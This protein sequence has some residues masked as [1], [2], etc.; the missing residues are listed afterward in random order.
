MAALDG[1]R[2][3]AQLTASGLYLVALVRCRSAFNGPAAAAQGRRCLSS[4]GQQRAG[5]SSERL[6]GAPAAAGLE[7]KVCIVTGGNAGVGKATA[8]ELAARGA[9][10]IIACRSAKKGEEAVQDISLDLRVRRAGKASGVQALPL[11]LSSFQ[12]IRS[13]VKEFDGLGLPLDVLVNN[14][15]IMA[16]PERAITV[17]GFESQW[18]VNYLGHFLLTQELL[19]V[20]NAAR[21]I[22]DA[23]LRIVNLTSMTHYGGHIHF[24]DLNFLR[25][26]HAFAAY[27]Q[28]KLAIV[29]STKELQRRQPDIVAVS[30]HPGLINTALARGFFM[31]RVPGPLRGLI[32]PLYDLFLKDPEE[33]VSTLM[34]A[35]TAPAGEV[36]GGFVMDGMVRQSHKKSYDVELAS[37]LWATSMDLK[38]PRRESW[39]DAAAADL[40]LPAG[41][42]LLAQHF[43]LGDELGRGKFGIVREATSHLNG[44]RY[45]CKTLDKGELA[46]PRDRQAVLR[47]VA[48]LRRAGGAAPGGV[49]ALQGV[50]ED[51]DG[52]H[53]VMELCASGDLFSHIEARGRLH[54]PEAAAVLADVAATVAALHAR[55][56]VHRDL[57]PENILLAERPRARGRY[58]AKIADF[59]LAVV[60]NGAERL[61]E[62]VGSPYYVA[63]EVILGTHGV[64]ADVWSL[65]VILYIL[66]SGVPPFWGDSDTRIYD[67]IC[68]QEPDLE[69]EPWPSVS[70]DAKSLIK[71]MLR[72]DPAVRITAKEVY[73]S[74][75][76]RQQSLHLSCSASL[77]STFQLPR[78]A[79]SSGPD[80]EEAK[81]VQAASSMV[82]SAYETA[83]ADS[84][85]EPTILSRFR[86]RLQAA[87][88]A[89]QKKLLEEVGGADRIH[90]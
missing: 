69:S 52:V 75:W 90:C 55:G 9:Q 18:Q 3:E 78:M 57:K 41:T 37:K 35:I 7:G 74:T 21:R 87:T 68:S 32:A 71:E 42:R 40:V 28:S 8:R 53:L 14:A 88:A 86:Q 84:T 4:S 2:R 45:A 47:E 11:D 54:E 51:P 81:A 49:V 70:A 63:P 89:L 64:E 33:A 1:A 25:R 67:A 29:L 6:L 5:S 36:A 27:A 17:D 77:R 79:S 46:T 73:H 24:D 19:R 48:I 61:A 10:V 59:G 12:S 26:Y 16:P 85:C 22:S 72:S 34:Y 56:I 82:G 23:P 43:S 65:G 31:S 44:R 20:P 13:F 80:V 39:S 30:V 38:R 62:F 60:L 83:G 58:F 15:G 50:Y 66:L 76:L